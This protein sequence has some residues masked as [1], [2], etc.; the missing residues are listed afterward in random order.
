MPLKKERTATVSRPQR[1]GYGNPRFV[2]REKGDYLRPYEGSN[3]RIFW[4]FS[5]KNS[6]WP[7]VIE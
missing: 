3:C 5:L 2:C 4:L 7:L 6:S 1:K